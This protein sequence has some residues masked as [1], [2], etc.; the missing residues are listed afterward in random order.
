M[1]DVRGD[2]SRLRTEDRF[3]RYF[4]LR[5][6]LLQVAGEMAN[7]RKASGP[8][9]RCFP[10]PFV[11]AR[12]IHHEVGRQWATVMPTGDITGEPSQQCI[13]RTQF[14]TE[15]SPFGKVV[16]DPL[17]QAD[18]RTHDLLPGHG[19]ATAA[20]LGVSSLA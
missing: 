6:E 14:E 20:S 3:L 1:E 4:S 16:V 15:A 2:A 12:P 17:L 19:N 10:V 13:P 7:P 5:F 11:L 8:G 18:A 9:C